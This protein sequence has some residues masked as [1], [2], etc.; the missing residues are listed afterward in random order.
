MAKP[1]RTSRRCW[2]DMPL[3]GFPSVLRRSVWPNVSPAGE[4]RSSTDCE[5]RADE[6]EA[7]NEPPPR[8]EDVDLLN[9]L[10]L[11]RQPLLPIWMPYSSIQ[12]SSTGLNHGFAAFHSS[13]WVR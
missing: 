1:T 3:R 6:V 2:G 12:F 10:N 7:L 8:S 4:L 9:S 13:A 5:L 11:P